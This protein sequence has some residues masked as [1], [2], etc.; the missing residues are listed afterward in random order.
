MLSIT[1]KILVPVDEK[2]LVRIDSLRPGPSHQRQVSA[3][4][5][6]QE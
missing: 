6:A 2:L 3:S 1:S 4:V 5:N